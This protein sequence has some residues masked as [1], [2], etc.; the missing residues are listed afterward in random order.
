MWR[1]AYASWIS[2]FYRD[3]RNAWLKGYFILCGSQLG[4]KKPPICQN[5][6]PQMGWAVPI[7]A[8]LEGLT[9]QTLRPRL[10][11]LIETVG[12]ILKDTRAQL[13]Y[14]SSQATL[15]VYE[16]TIAENVRQAAE[17]PCGMLYPRMYPGK[18]G[19]VDWC[20]RGAPVSEVQT[21]LNTTE[22]NAVHWCD[23][24]Y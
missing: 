17:G 4:E 24:S 18:L 15:G 12:S 21:I 7:A 6:C 3:E 1:A 5:Q 10:A 14:A 13:R 19:S 22:C 9:I 23:V 11:T 8:S 16:K 20:F 2:Y